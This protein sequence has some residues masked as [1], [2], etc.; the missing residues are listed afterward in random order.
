MTFFAGT[1]GVL[2]PIAMVP[3]RFHGFLMLN[4]MAIL[5]AAFQDALYGAQ[6]PS[7][8]HLAPV[9]LLAVVVLAGA[10]AFADRM[11]WGLAEEI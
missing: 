5:V 11:R 6:M 2:Y 4:P 10:L 1:T 3:A 7:F 8:T 9:A